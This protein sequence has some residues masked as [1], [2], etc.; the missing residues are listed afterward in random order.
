[1]PQEKDVAALAK[2]GEHLRRRLRR[3]AGGEEHE[4]G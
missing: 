3:G 4:D 2:G 1:M